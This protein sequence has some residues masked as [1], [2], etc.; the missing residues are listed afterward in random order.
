MLR[1]KLK[2]IN[3]TGSEKLAAFRRPDILQTVLKNLQHLHETQLEQK[4]PSAHLNLGSHSMDCR[5]WAWAPA[6]ATADSAWACTAV[7][8][9]CRRKVCGAG[10]QDVEL[11]EPPVPPEPAAGPPAE[12]QSVGLG[13][14]GRAN[15]AR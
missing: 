6:P 11:L 9:G 15:V 3:R 12:P 8:A 4:V 1:V 13:L 5:T 2:V 7:T 10:P 14:E